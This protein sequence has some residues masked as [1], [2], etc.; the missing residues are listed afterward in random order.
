MLE[1]EREGGKKGGR[2]VQVTA[3]ALIACNV[4]QGESGMEQK[5]L[6][7]LTTQKTEIGNEIMNSRISVLPVTRWPFTS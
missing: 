4:W 3:L 7:H 1:R 6:M 2:S 5:Y